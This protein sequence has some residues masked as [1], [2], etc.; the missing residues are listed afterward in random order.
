MANVVVGAAYIIYVV[1]HSLFLHEFKILGND[2]I[3][4]TVD[5]LFITITFSP[6]PTLSVD[7]RA[8]LNIPKVRPTRFG[9]IGNDL[10]P[11]GVYHYTT[12]LTLVAVFGSK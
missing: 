3:T 12:I 7:L 5:T 8:F 11:K 9:T 6:K 1:Y 10:H 4:G 2:F